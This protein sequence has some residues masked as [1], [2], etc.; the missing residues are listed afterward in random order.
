[1]LHCVRGVRMRRML[2][3]PNLGEPPRLAL[4]QVGGRTAADAEVE[5]A[6]LLSAVAAVIV[7]VDDIATQVAGS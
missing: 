6:G 7:S 2:Q 3:L 1:M 5:E 4:L